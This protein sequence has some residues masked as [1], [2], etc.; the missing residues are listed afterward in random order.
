MRKGLLIVAALAFLAALNGCTNWEQKYK[1]LDVEHQNLRGLYDNCEGA[2]GSASTERSQL[3]AQLSES[4]RTIEDLRRQI[5]SG[6]TP[7]EATGFGPGMDVSVD[8]ARGTVTVSLSDTILFSPGQA[9][10][11]QNTVRE[12]DQVLGVI[13]ERYAGKQIEVVGHT[14]SDPIRKTAKLWKDNWE[15]S[16]ERS[17]TV[18]RYMVQRGIAPN[19]IRAVACGESRPRDS[20]SNAAG[21]SRNRRVE[22]VVSM[23]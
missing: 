2:L 16:A 12:L 17:L 11:K 23:R 10:L 3:S 19:Q 13:Q 21:K 7:G 6:K 4:Q 18:L 8:T 5:A 22:I 1:D 14:D 9:S 20:N 15:L